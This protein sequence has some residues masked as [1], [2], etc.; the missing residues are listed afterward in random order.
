MSTDGDFQREAENVARQLTVI[1]H[2]LE[3]S[4]VV[5]AFKTAAEQ[6]EFALD[7]NQSVLWGHDFDRAALD[8]WF[9]LGDHLKELSDEAERR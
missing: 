8:R 6:L 4:Q 3:F 7:F 2:E 1:A 9:Q 5:D